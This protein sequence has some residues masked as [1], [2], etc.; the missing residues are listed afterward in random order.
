MLADLEW[1]SPHQT[2]MGGTL[3]EWVEF[4]RR[5]EEAGKLRDYEEMKLRPEELERRR[6]AGKLCIC[7]CWRERC[8]RAMRCRHYTQLAIKEFSPEIR[9][10]LMETLG[11]AHDHHGPIDQE[12]LDLLR[13][14]L[15]GLGQGGATPPQAVEP[16]ATPPQTDK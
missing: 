9:I 14:H 3:E 15:S 6:N 12:K 2:P 5:K 8:R 7:L 4:V 10:V 1:K 13:E 16:A 11:L